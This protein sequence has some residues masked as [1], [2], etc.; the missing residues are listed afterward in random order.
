MKEQSPEQRFLAIYETHADA[1]FRHCYYRVEHR[2]L[3][4][5]LAQ[6]AFLRTWQYLANGHSIDNMRAFLYRVANN[7]IID[8]RRK[9][10]ELS[11]DTLREEGFE[12]ASEAHKKVVAGAEIAEITQ[13][14][15]QLQEKEREVIILRYINDLQPKEIAYILGEST[16]VI[17]VRLHRAVQRLQT[18]IHIDE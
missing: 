12:P 5:D 1:I 9:A 4:H 14:L 6:E 18:L 7:V 8:D 2:E 15:E 3:A 11:L 13:V 17:S 16:N 10:K